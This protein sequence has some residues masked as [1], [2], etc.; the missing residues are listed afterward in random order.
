MAKA[1]AD[2]AELRRFAQELKRFNAELQSNM[3]SVQARMGTLSQ[4]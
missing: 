4:S 1:V 2:P 3:Q